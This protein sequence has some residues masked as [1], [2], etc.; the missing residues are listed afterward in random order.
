MWGNMFNIVEKKG[1]CH[2]HG[3]YTVRTM[4]LYKS[5]VICP[6]C[7]QELAAERNGGKKQ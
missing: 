2:V 6:H 1:N 5:A 7:A 3:E 4:E